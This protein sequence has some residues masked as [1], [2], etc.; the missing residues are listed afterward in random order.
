MAIWRVSSFNWITKSAA[1]FPISI[2][3]IPTPIFFEN[4]LENTNSL[5]TPTVFPFAVFTS[6]ECW[7]AGTEAP[8]ITK[9][10]RLRFAPFALIF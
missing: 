4:R 6:R 7:Q 8:E 2:A 1:S 5:R 9:P 3:I 10:V